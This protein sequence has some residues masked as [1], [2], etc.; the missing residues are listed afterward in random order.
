MPVVNWC[1][2]WYTPRPKFDNISTDVLKAVKER[3]DAQDH[4][5]PEMAAFEAALLLVSIRPSAACRRSPH[6]EQIVARR[7]GRPM[8]SVKT[9]AQRSTTISCPQRH[10]SIQGYR[11]GWQTRIDD[12][13]NDW[14]K[15][16]L[17]S[18]NVLVWSGL[19]SVHV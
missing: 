8:G 7:A 19:S 10:A 3:L 15:D 1:W 12:A 9:E 14:L 2:C 16:A 18:V 11:Q 4:K 17:A 5:D 13:L 6:A